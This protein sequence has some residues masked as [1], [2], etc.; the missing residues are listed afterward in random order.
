MALQWNVAVADSITVRSAGVVV[1]LGATGM[2]QFKFNPVVTVLR[3]ILQLNK[4]KRLDFLQ[5][6]AHI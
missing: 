4:T 1:K 6:V 3:A 5:Y 2:K